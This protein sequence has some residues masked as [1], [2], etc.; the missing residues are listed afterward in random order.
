MR[1]YLDFMGTLFDAS[2]HGLYIDAASFL[3]EKENATTIITSGS[4]DSFEST[5]KDTLE[6]IPRMSVM[7]TDG[8]KKG[9]YLAPHTHLHKDAV[10]VDDSPGELAVLAV[11][12]PELKLF[13]MRRDGGAGDG[14]WPVIRSFSELA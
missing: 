9:Q 11:E 5:V 13:E 14:R 12:C 1:Y 10:L 6:G 8:V 2:Q 7:Y 3:R 4:K